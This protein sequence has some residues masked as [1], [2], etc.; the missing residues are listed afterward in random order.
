MKKPLN[1][2]KSNSNKMYRKELL[3]KKAELLTALGF[4]FKKLS[5]TARNSDDDLIVALQDE[6]LHSG[7]DRVLYGQLQDVE[8]ALERMKAGEFGVC[9]GCGTSISAKRLQAIPWANYCVECQDRAF[10][11]QPQ[12]AAT[13]GQEIANT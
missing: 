3:T 7:L 6:F 12:Q 11:G 5:D 4:N 9:A 2:S 8:S 1:G 10:V 13:G